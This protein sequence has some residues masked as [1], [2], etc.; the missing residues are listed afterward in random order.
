MLHFLLAGR[1]AVVHHMGRPVLLAVA[2]AMGEMASGSFDMYRPAEEYSDYTCFHLPDCSSVPLPSMVDAMPASFA[3]RI[4]FSSRLILS[5]V[6]YGRNAE[7]KD[8]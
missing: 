6:R 4:A 5:C 3:A 7:S 1:D 2:L 8:R